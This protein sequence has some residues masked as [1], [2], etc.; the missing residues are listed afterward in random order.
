MNQQETPSS[1]PVI[2]SNVHTLGAVHIPLHDYFVVRIKAD[3]ELDDARKQKVVMQRFAG[4]K[5]DVA[6][7]E[8][9]GNW[10]SAKFREFG[11]FQLVLDESPPQIVPL[12]FADGSNV[13]KATRLSFTIKDNLEDFKNFRA[14]L[15][16]KWLRFTNDKGR[17]F[18]Y[19]FDEH[20]PRGAHELKISVEDEAGNQ[21]TEVYRLIR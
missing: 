2:I 10:A 6:R 16:G 1:N 4:S 15:D 3:A 21:A 17:L 5:K 7:V 8:W 13:S 19:R 14:E 11:S 12:G 20:F 18:H 9:Q